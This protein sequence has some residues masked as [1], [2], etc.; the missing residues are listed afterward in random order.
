M[1]IIDNRL[2][3]GLFLCFFQE[4]GPIAL[5]RV[6]TP[7]LFASGGVPLLVCRCLKI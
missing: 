4:N 6:A 3:A 2:A 7:A 1:I 5:S